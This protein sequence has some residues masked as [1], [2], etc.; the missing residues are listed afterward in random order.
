MK[1][2]IEKVNDDHIWKE[3]YYNILQTNQ[4][5]QKKCRI[6]QKQKV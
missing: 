2:N 5:K 4:Q 3:F 6:D 1:I